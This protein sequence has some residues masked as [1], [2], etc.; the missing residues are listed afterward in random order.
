LNQ[1]DRGQYSSRS[2]GAEYLPLVD[3][4]VDIAFGLMLLYQHVQQNAINQEKSHMNGK[5]AFTAD[6]LAQ[7]LYSKCT[8]GSD[9]E[10]AAKYRQRLFL[11]ERPFLSDVLLFKAVKIQ[12]QECTDISVEEYR[13]ADAE[14]KDSRSMDTT[15][16]VT[17]LELVALEQLITARQQLVHELHSEQYPV[18]NEFEV[19]YA[20]KCGL[21]EQCLQI[22][23]H[24]VRHIFRAGFPLHQFHFIGFPDILS[25]LDGELVSLL[26]IIRLLDPDPIPL[27]CVK[28]FATNFII[29]T[30]TLSL[31]LMAQCHRKLRSKS[32]RDTLHLT[33]FAC[34]GLST[35]T[36]CELDIPVLKM[37]YRSLKL[38]S[39][40]SISAN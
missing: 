25:L 29:C 9:T 21:F 8:A 2:I 20:Y 32:V 40:D 26:G 5:L 17:T 22:C 23:E 39:D 14:I 7:Y 12:M 31:Y 16:L 37:T 18:L 30:A 10:W 35:Y 28:G 15:M 19:L 4:N 34:D 1:C 36:D 24:Y 33:R 38:Y 11:T 3:E 27:L 13:T 6:L